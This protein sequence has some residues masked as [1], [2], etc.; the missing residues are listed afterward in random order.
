MTAG[1]FDDIPKGRYGFVAIDPPWHFTTHSAKG[2][3][4][5]PSRHYQTMTKAEIL[6]LPVLDI[7]APDA[8]VALWTTGTHMQI[9]FDCVRAWGL[10]Y[11]GS[12][13]V[14]IKLNKTASPSVDGRFAISDL[15]MN[16]GYT[17]RK[18]AEFVLFLKRGAPKRL[19]A[20]TREV[21]VS[22][23]REHS[24]KPEEFY[25]RAERLFPGPRIDV[26]ARQR[27]PGWD[28]WGNETGKFEPA[29]W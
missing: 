22:P 25:D 13:F 4:R 10:K 20:R 29:S 19:N 1:I 15:F 6:A 14:W 23:R 18:N 8:M 21:I 5:S 12:G 11:S 9:A 27:R 17:T 16:T 28:A 3:G 7:L 2:Q 26:F 24:R